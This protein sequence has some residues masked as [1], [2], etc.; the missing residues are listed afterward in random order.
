MPPHCDSMDGPVVVAARAALEEEEF[1]RIAPYVDADSEDEL[2]EAFEVTTKAW[3]QG[4][5]ARVV[6][7]RYFFE[8]AVRLHRMGEGAPFEGLKPA[9]LDVGPVIPA[10][11]R[12][13]AEGSSHDLIELLSREIK[14]GVNRRLDETLELQAHVDESTEAARAYV[15]AMLGLQVWSHGVYKAIHA[16]GHG[17]GHHH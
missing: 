15:E 16:G 5:E 10:A 11:E 12:A 6:S 4:P 13:I 17:N 8:T 14:E 7:E 2:R 9:G 3:T 1:E